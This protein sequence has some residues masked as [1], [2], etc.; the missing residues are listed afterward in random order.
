[1]NAEY[2][3][4][5]ERQRLN[6]APRFDVM[7]V[8]PARNEDERIGACL[9]SILMAS[10]HASRRVNRVAI[11]V[12]A[13]GCTDRTVEVAHSVLSDRALSV[14]TECDLGN[15]ALARASGVRAGRVLLGSL[16]SD[17][18]WIASTDADTTVPRTWIAQQMAAATQGLCAV[19]GVVDVET[20]DG[21]PHSAERHF[22]DTYTALLP[23]H[24]DHPHV[25]AANL[26]VRVDAYDD[27]GGWGHLPR[28]EDRDLWNR[29]REI[30]ASTGS[31][32]GL[33]VV[34]SGRSIGR[35]PGG[36]AD[37]L[38]DQVLE[39]EQRENCEGETCNE[40]SACIVDV[41]QKSA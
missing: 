39:R 8:I 22:A 20:F 3:S 6:S 9:G 10:H 35:V 27:A 31:P 30:G 17:R 11:V 1:M 5:V 7:V 18:T 24:G 28:S 25:H 36:F 34:T 38:R 16:R 2:C 13:D 40:C 32:T 26:G 14:V 29:L 23:T 15:V 4:S 12:V 37:C 33:R 21:L 19:A 41:T